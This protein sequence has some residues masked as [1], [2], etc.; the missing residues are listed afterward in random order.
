MYSDEAI[1]S[2]KE[3]ASVNFDAT[4]DAC[5]LKGLDEAPDLYS[6][7]ADE[8]NLSINTYPELD[9]NLVIPLCCTIG[10]EGYYTIEALEILNFNDPA[11][12]FLEDKFEN[13]FIDLKNQNSYTFYGIASD[14][15]E[16][17]TLHFIVNPSNA[18]AHT[19]KM[20][21]QLYAADHSIY[22][23]R[24]DSGLLDGTIK[25]FDIIGRQ[26]F[27]T[28]VEGTDQFEIQIDHEGI[29]LIKYFDNSDQKEYRQKVLLK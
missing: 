1:I 15:S 9:E 14:A 10:E 8:K 20:E 7:S 13:I 22:L 23:K 6:V 16:R 5:N 4:D 17:F 28:S 27:V 29:L 12:L 2:F 3:N 19:E 21:I 18:I 11:R 25:G 26:I 24:H